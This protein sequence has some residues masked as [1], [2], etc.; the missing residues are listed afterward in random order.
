[1]AWKAAELFDTETDF[2]PASPSV[3]THSCEAPL[4]SYSRW[5]TWSMSSGPSLHVEG[6][7]F[8]LYW[9]IFPPQ[10]A[11]FLATV[12]SVLVLAEGLR[13]VCPVHPVLR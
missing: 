10:S 8:V 1:M 2:P 9:V 12:C 5:A 7:A 6:F 13:V 4:P 3:W 11:P